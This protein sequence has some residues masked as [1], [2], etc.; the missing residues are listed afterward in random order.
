MEA[1]TET[2]TLRSLTYG[3]KDPAADAVAVWG[4]RAIY[5]RDRGAFE[6]NYTKSG[7]PRKRGRVPWFTV[8][9]LWDRKDATGD[10][11]ALKRLCDWLDKVA[12][13]KLRMEI[14]LEPSESTNYTIEDEN[15]TLHANPRASYGYLYITAWVR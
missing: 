2:T 15:F 7:K 1:T 12:L 14:D 5:S 9:L 13:P 6:Q 11:A 8:D 3:L 4:A 10:K